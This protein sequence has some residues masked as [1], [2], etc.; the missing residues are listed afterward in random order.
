MADEPSISMKEHYDEVRKVE[1][2]AIKVALDA[3]NEKA[4]THNDILKELERQQSTY[5]TK[6]QM[7]WAI[8]SLLAGIAVATALFA[9]I[10]GAG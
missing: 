3:A 5:V 6:E 1:R 2:E 8:T 7:R 4:R 10:T 9:A